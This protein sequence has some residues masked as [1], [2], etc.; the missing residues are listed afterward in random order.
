MTEDLISAATSEVSNEGL[1]DTSIVDV[2]VGEGKKYKS[3]DDLA[4][5]RITAD[6]HIKQIEF[7]NSNMRTELDSLASQRDNSKTIEDILVKLDQANS[8]GETA[9]TGTEFTDPK[10]ITSL[11][12]QTLQRRDNQVAAQ[13]NRATVNAA[14][15]DYFQGDSARAVKHVQETVRSAGLT[16]EQFANLS[17]SAPAA[18]L[19]VLNI[20]TNARPPSSP[21]MVERGDINP[22][23]SFALSSGNRDK[24]YYD[25]IKKERGFSKFHR[26]TKLQTQMHEDY[27]KLKEQGQWE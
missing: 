14:L 10:A 22:E 12:E 27:A 21:S 8:G 26:D 3:V 23:S 1:A 18:A 4:K 7:E 9:L 19:S 13:G 2:L 15:S 11:V 6:E 25:G 24:A 20:K 17:E 16:D 5:S